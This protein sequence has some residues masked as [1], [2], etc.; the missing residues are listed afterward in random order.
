MVRGMRGIKVNKKQL[1]KKIFKNME[2]EKPKSWH[3][4]TQRVVH[5]NKKKEADK[6]ACRKRIVI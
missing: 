3:I 1:V 5:K 4:T 6:Y 2:V